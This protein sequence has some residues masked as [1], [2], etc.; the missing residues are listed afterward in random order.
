MFKKKIEKWNPS[1]AAIFNFT[2][3]HEKNH[4][5]TSKCDRMDFLASKDVAA[6]GESRNH[7]IF[8]PSC[9]DPEISKFT[10][11]W[12]GFPSYFSMKKLI[13]EFRHSDAVT[14][15]QMKYYLRIYFYFRS[16]FK[17]TDEKWN[18]S[19][20]RLLWSLFFTWSH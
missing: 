15:S 10:L 19:E 17:E 6:C 20:C 7:F 2:W 11:F 14:R 5:S 13:I 18:P 3:S 12:P 16:M 1:E 4:I 8:I 9:L